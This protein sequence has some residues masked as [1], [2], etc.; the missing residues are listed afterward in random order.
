V[1]AAELADLLTIAEDATGAAEAAFM[2][3][4]RADAEPSDWTAYTCLAN[5][6]RYIAAAMVLAGMVES[7]P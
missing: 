4:A 2:L 1:S 3:R 7:A 6:R 5:A